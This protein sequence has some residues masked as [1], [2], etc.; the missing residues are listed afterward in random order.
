MT[1][2][3]EFIYINI[4]F[5]WMKSDSENS[6]EDL[7][8][9]NQPSTVTLSPSKDQASDSLKNKKKNKKKKSHCNLIANLAGISFIRQKQNTPW[10]RGWLNQYWG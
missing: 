8:D 3:N 4:L 9:K 6:C 7:D 5:D 1:E 2:M 10:S